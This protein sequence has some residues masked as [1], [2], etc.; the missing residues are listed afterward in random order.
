MTDIYE[1]IEQYENQESNIYD[2]I[3]NQESD[4][5]QRDDEEDAAFA[6][7]Q[8]DDE[9]TARRIDPKKTKTHVRN[10]LPKLDTEKLK[11]SNG[12]QAIEKYFENFKFHGKGREKADLDRIMKRLEYWSYRL[13][14]KYHFDDFLARVEQLGSKKDLQVFI[15]KYRL[16]MIAPDNDL[17]IEDNVDSEEEQQE[18]APLDDFD[19]LI[20]EQIQKQKQAETR[21]S[22]SAAGPNTAEDAFDELVRSSKNDNTQ[23]SQVEDTNTARNHELSDEIKERI[24]RNRQ[25][26]IQRK[27]Q[28]WREQEEAK[29]LK[30]TESTN[31]KTFNDNL[32]TEDKTDASQTDI[33]LSQNNENI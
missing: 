26:A 8:K 15:K 28:R 3:E 6:N 25:L 24:E 23:S 16:D 14:P 31:D 29:K 32:T 13:F 10:P 1:D 21:A 9:G 30:L 4:G 33:T 17:I 22:A 18:N 12:V 11:G 20:T 27:L 19:L 5:N 2:D 7:D